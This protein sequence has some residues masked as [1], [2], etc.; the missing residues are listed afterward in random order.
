MELLECRMMIRVKERASLF[1]LYVEP[2]MMDAG[3]VNINGEEKVSKVSKDEI[4]SALVKG[5]SLRAEQSLNILPT[6]GESSVI[7]DSFE[8][9]FIP[10]GPPFPLMTIQVYFL[11]SRKILFLYRKGN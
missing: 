8:G 9:K 3:M 2:R 10:L 7:H 4:E 6:M 5:I 11:L 1:T